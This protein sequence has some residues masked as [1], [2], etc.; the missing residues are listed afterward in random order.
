MENKLLI[1]RQKELNSKLVDLFQKNGIKKFRLISLGNSI[2]SGYSAVRTLKPLLLRN[3]SLNMIMNNNGIDL[4]IHHFARAQN[5]NDEHIFEWLSSNVKESEIHKLNRNDYSGG[6]SSLPSPGINKNQ[7]D[8]YYPLDMDDDIGLQDAIVENDEGMANIIIYNG[9]TGSFLDNITRNGKLNHMFTYGVNRD[10]I[11]LEATLKFILSKNRKNNSNTQV[12]ICGAPDFLGI[13]LSEIINMKLKK[14]VEKYP[15][16]VYVPPVKTKFFYKPLDV[17]SGM[18]L[19]SIQ[20]LIRKFLRYPDIHYDEEEYLEFINNILKTIDENYLVV[21]SLIN[22]DRGLYNFSSNIEI[23]NQDILNNDEYICQYV[24]MLLIKECSL[25][26]DDDSRELIYNRISQYLI[27]R[28]PYD[29]YYIGKK[30]INKSINNIE[31][32]RK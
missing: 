3:E 26:K 28:L 19:E 2:G 24:G 4:D 21:K 27:N 9:C 15:N 1:D 32:K 17:D 12:Y 16:T 23:E 8:E 22:V 14:I 6:A 11:S 5:N 18:K 13:K 29:F 25:I 30:N 31:K 7:F 20:S 10:I